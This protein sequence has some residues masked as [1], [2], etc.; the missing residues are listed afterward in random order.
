MKPAGFP[1]RES[2]A[3]AC[4]PVR[5]KRTGR[6]VGAGRVDPARACPPGER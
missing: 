5:E 2:P 6:V 3:L 1:V 4:S